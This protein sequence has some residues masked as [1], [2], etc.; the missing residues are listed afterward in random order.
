MKK[1][2]VAL[3]ALAATGAFA[4]VT[5]TGGVRAA[6]QNTGVANAQT[7]VDANDVAANNLMITAVEDLGGG[8][9][10]TGSYLMRNDITT[11]AVSPAT[12][13]TLTAPTAGLWRNTYIALDGGFGQ[14]KAGRWGNGGQFAFDAFG[15]TGIVAPYVN[16]GGGRYNNMVQYQ[17]PTMSGFSAQIGASMS[18]ATAGN[19]EGSWLYLNYSNGPLAAR[20]LSEKNQAATASQTQGT[21]VSASYDFGVAKALVSY[22]RTVNISTSAASA[23]GFSLGATAPMG[24][25]TLKIG[26]ANNYTATTPNTVVGVGVNY[27]LSKTSGFFFD[28]GKTS[29]LSNMTWQLGIE[30]Y[31]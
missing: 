3:A 10:V 13:A 14:V 19:E 1:T 29:T 27:A 4:Q 25:A 15:A 26:F 28:A 22:A 9:K 7:T 18:G 16:A 6:L 24:A 23:E 2:L 12:T 11:G 8:M 30:K 5:I 17:T 31:F 21:G 20:V